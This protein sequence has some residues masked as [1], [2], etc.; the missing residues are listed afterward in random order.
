MGYFKRYTHLAP[1]AFL[2]FAFGALMFFALLRSLLNNWVFELYIEPQY[3]FHYYGFDWVQP[4][5]EWTYLLWAVAM[6]SAIGVCVGYLYRLSIITFTITF[7]YIELM[8]VAYYLNHYYFVT[9]LAFALCWLPAAHYGSMDAWLGRAKSADEAPRWTVDLP[10][11]LVSILYFFAGLAKMNSD[12]LI[13]AQPLKMWLPSRYDLPILGELVDEPWLPYA[14]AWFGMLYDTTIW[15][16]LWWKRTRIFAYITVIIFHTLTAIFFPA[17]G[18]FPYVMIVITLVFFDAKWQLALGK[19]FP[20]APR[21]WHE[22]RTWNPALAKFIL[23]VFLAWQI[24]YPMRS[25]L[26]PGELFW[27]EQGFRFSW[28]VMLMEKSGAA[29]FKVVEGSTGR[30]V[31]VDPSEYLNETQE[32]QM[33][34]QPDLLLQFAHYLGSLYEEAGMQNPEVYVRSAVSLNA[35]PSQPIVD[36]SIDLMQVKDGWGHKKWITAWNDEIHGW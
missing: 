27:T 14:F 19:V 29:E 5:G 9:I 11:V 34:F 7:T 28:R 17:I 35:R 2:R 24:F 32:K 3:H 22:W 16:F 15:I 31:W 20:S 33:A 18:V 36:E 10:R 12:W 21:K 25:Q 23:P 4:L 26:Y 30:Y 8:D 13:E 1:L 6:I